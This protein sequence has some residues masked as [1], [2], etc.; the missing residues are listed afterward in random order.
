MLFSCADK[1]VEPCVVCLVSG[2]VMNR[3]PGFEYPADFLLG[4]QPVLIIPTTTETLRVLWRKD[5]DVPIGVQTS[6]TPGP[7]L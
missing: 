3:L 5:Q 7:L 4:H 1:E 6:L 2:D